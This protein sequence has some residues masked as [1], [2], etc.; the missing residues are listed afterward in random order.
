MTS[1]QQ[2]VCVGPVFSTPGRESTEKENGNGVLPVFQMKKNQQQDCG[3][4]A[5]V[6]TLRKDRSKKRF[7][8]GVF[9]YVK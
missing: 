8:T 7:E 4:E 2:A 9:R 1:F 6:L 3:G 5:T